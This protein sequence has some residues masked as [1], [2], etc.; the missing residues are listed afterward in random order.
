MSLHRQ[1]AL[2]LTG[3]LLVMVVLHLWLVHTF[4]RYL[5]EEY[6]VSRLQHDGDGLLSRLRLSPQ[7]T[8]AIASGPM[9]PI[10]E[11]PHSGHYFYIAHGATEITARSLGEHTLHV[12]PIATGATRIEHV[13]GPRGEPLLVWVAG[14]EVQG[15]PVTLAVAEEISHLKNDIAVMQRRY[16]IAIAAAIVALIAVQT[17]ILRRIL[18]P[19]DAARAEL[20]EIAEG[21][22]ARID[23]PLPGEFQPFIDELNRLIGLQQQRLERYRKATGNLAH[24]LKT[25]IS[26]LGQ[27]LESDTIRRDL[28]I[29]RELG[30]IQSRL[31]TLVDSELRRARLAGAAAPGQRLGVGAELRD[32]CRVLERL[33]QDKTVTCEVCAP[34]DLRFAA[35]REDFLELFGNLLDNACKWAHSRVRVEVGPGPDLDV[36]IEDDGPGATPEATD[37]LTTRGLRL[38]ESTP[39]H[40]LGLSI[41]EDIVAQYGGTLRF[42]RSEALGGLACHLTLPTTRTQA[43]GH[44]G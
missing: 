15:Q 2:W 39:G 30:A 22:R 23:L 44:S 19:I 28:A 14:V 41:V 3:T 29:E 18:T 24:A 27:L 36:T 5:T 34:G 26:L 6:V 37:K 16:L 35:D 1:L 17:L 12:A 31:R 40:G 20:R 7:G 43:A 33:H 9:A 21:R 10:Y 32:L 38:D 42:A 13:P 4:P 11:T 8:L 25:P